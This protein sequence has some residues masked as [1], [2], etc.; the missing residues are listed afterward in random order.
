MRRALHLVALGAAAISGCSLA[1]P[2]LA[3]PSCEGHLDCEHFNTEH[4][5]RVNE[6]ERYQ[7]NLA[8]HRCY[9]G[10]RD[11]DGDGHF[12]IVE[13]APVGDDCDDQVDRA[14]AGLEE[15][16][17]GIDNDCDGIVDDGIPVDHDAAIA[18]GELGMV[19][20]VSWSA[21]DVGATGLGTRADMGMSEDRAV[22][23]YTVDAA[24]G[25]QRRLTVRGLAEPSDLASAA[26]DDGCPSG[27]DGRPGTCTLVEAAVA[28]GD[29]TGWAAF[30]SDEGCTS[31][32][33]RVGLLDAPSDEIEIVGPDTRSNLWRGVDLSGACTRA[34]GAATGATAP[35]IAASSGAT[36][37]LAWIRDAL[38]RGCGDSAAEVAVL[39]LWRATG[40]TTA[41]DPIAWAVAS[42]GG[43]PTTVGRTSGST[44]PALAAT[45]GGET[46]VAF[47][48]ETGG[49]RVVVV[50][51]LPALPSPLAPEATPAVTV[52]ESTVLGAGVADS[53][54]IL[55]TPEGDDLR[56]AIAWIAGCGTGEL[57]LA[58]TLFRRASRAF[59][60]GTESTIAPSASRPALAFVPHGFTRT[61]FERGGAAVGD[62]NGGWV[63]AWRD[64]TMSPPALVVTR[65]L[66]ADGEAL[67]P[68]PLPIAR[69]LSADPRAPF[70]YPGV[71]EGADFTVRF[72]LHA[73]DAQA[74][75]GGTL[76]CA[77]PPTP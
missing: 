6:C 33:L 2:R 43:V 50:D 72:A 76:L 3:P 70:L 26:L 29:P 30:V 16:C 22:A 18:V 61:S 8:T 1:L 59:E 42:G 68:T 56:V 14:Y 24:T 47:P 21:D 10:P 5:E 32:Q 54:A 44:A 15:T 75:V 74:I 48:D 25:A 31:G 40:T 36:A 65:V 20:D 73:A 51:R 7:C 64:A 69:D 46:L 71:G 58:T 9:F 38:G 37:T 63:L 39:G 12:P 41:S 60:P 17:D 35:A 34:T 23:L 4:P 66:A 57:H 49:V 53:V 19:V 45:G 77:P 11:R 27:A 13:C 62:A 52:G 67:D 28:A 55:A